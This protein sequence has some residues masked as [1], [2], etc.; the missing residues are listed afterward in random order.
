MVQGSFL[1]RA[2]SDA[3][4][5]PFGVEFEAADRERH[6]SVATHAHA[7]AERDRPAVGHCTITQ[8]RQHGS[9]RNLLDGGH[10]SPGD[11]Q[12]SQV[13]GFRTR[14]RS[15][16]ETS[17]RFA[18]P[19]SERSKSTIAPSRVTSSTSASSTMLALY[20]PDATW[21]ATWPWWCGASRCRDDG[22][23]AAGTH[24]RTPTCGVAITHPGVGRRR[25][26][27]PQAGRRRWSAPQAAPMPPPHI[28]GVTF[29]SDQ[30][31]GTPGP[32]QPARGARRPGQPAPGLPPVRLQRRLRCPPD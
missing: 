8:I 29:G 20:S 3:G 26:G 12:S 15:I 14:I 28:T 19:S 13:S 27:P 32:V 2:D 21:F 16:W 1:D 23:Q 6:H 7:H 10:H 30:A 5:H 4:V 24:N 18:E 17:A 25:Q 22:L 9:R 31:P 11:H